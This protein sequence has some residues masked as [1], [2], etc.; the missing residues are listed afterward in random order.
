MEGDAEI[1]FP[2]GRN[3]EQLI[4]NWTEK[5]MQFSCFFAGKIIENHEN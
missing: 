3:I 5:L 4:E 1:D 2:M